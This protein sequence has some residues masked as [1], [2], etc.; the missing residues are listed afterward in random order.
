MSIR[1][2]SKSIGTNDAKSAEI[3][4]AIRKAWLKAKPETQAEIAAEFK[5]GYIAGREKVSLAQ[6]EVIFKAGKGAEAINPAAIDRA[7]SAFNYHI[8]QSKAQAPKEP[9]TR[10]RIPTH[11]REAAMDFLAEFKGETLAEQIT[12]ALAVLNSL[13]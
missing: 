11:L 10:H 5:I 8:K 9:E 12:Q 13:K 7:T 3:A 2:N 4:A 6:A 1:T